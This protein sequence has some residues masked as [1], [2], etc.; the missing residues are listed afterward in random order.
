MDDRYEAYL[1]LLEE[2]RGGVE[3]LTGLARQKAEAVHHNDLMALDEVIRQEQVLS[4][5][6]R[7]QEQR[8]QA[9][10]SQLGLG[11]VPLSK[12]ADHYPPELRTRAKE[13]AEALRGS[14]HMYKTVSDAARKTLEYELH[15]I[16]RV[17]AAE[18]GPSAQGAGYTSPTVEPPKNMKTDFRA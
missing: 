8:R 1:A 3:R 11:D 15:E 9:L 12:L 16:E 6:L 5:S 18:G 10:L 2:V 4:L 13:T 17:I 14:Y 7:G